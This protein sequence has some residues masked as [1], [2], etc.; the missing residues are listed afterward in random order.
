V[1]LDLLIREDRNAVGLQVR[2]RGPTELRRRYTRAVLGGHETVL[3]A[4]R[5][6]LLL[7]RPLAQL[8]ELGAG[9]PLLLLDD[10]GTQRR[11]HLE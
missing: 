3:S 6:T 9:S 4:G 2:L 10:H 1:S 11:A 5:G 7:E 8:G